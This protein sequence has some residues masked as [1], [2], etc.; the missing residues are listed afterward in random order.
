MQSFVAFAIAY[1]IGSVDFGVIVPRLMGR[2]I[3]AE[4]SGTPD[5]TLRNVGGTR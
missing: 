1:L 3:Y 4:G 5:R 2:D